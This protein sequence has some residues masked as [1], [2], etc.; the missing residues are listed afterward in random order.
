MNCGAN[1]ISEGDSTLRLL[2]VCGEPTQVEQFEDR[3]P[4]ARF[5]ED[6]GDYV[7]EY[8]VRAYEVWTYNYGPRHLIQ[9]LT[10]RYGKV[11]RI[12]TGGYGF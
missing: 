4:L 3:L 10:I 2:T 5:Q 9:R 8:E 1:L 6:T 11:Y 7:T 12:E